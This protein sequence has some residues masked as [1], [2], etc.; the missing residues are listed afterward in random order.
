MQVHFAF[1]EAFFSAALSLADV[2]FGSLVQVTSS[3]IILFIMLERDSDRDPCDYLFFHMLKDDYVFG[4]VF[5]CSVHIFGDTI[6]HVGAFHHL[7]HLSI[8][9][10]A[11]FS[12][13]GCL[14]GV[15][16]L[17]TVLHKIDFAFLTRKK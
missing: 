10:D 11:C 6:A 17:D 12:I 2:S 8:Y 7:G 13:G 15:L 1:L 16:T 5:H 9:F 3:R 14:W 4:G